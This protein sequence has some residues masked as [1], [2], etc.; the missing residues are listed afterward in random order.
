MDDLGL[1]QHQVDQNGHDI[2]TQLVKTKDFENQMKEIQSFAND[3]KDWVTNGGSGVIQAVPNWQEPTMLT[4]STG[5]GGKMAFSGN[6]L[7]FYD[8]NGNQEPRAG[9]DSEGRI[10]ADAIKAGTIEAVNIKSCL[11]ES[12]LTIGTSGGSMNVYIGTNNPR[13]ILNPW[14]GG[15]VIWAMSDNY[16]SMVSSGQFATTNGSDYTRIHPSAITVGDDDNQVLTQRNFAAHA[17]RRIKSWV[18][19]WIADWITINGTRHTIWKGIDNGA[20]MGKLRDLPGQGRNDYRYT[21]GSNDDYGYDE[22]AEGDGTDLG[23]FATP[24]DIQITDKNLWNEINNMQ[25][26]INNIQINPPTTEIDNPSSWGTSSSDKSKMLTYTEASNLGLPT[27]VAAGTV[28][29]G[30]DG[31]PYRYMEYTPTGNM[32]WFRP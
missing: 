1:I 31:R 19:L 8:A 23:Q 20:Y 3:I 2:A 22:G 21:P 27:G 29:V 9:M 28:T 26:K 6:G 14:K 15:N 10:Y 4:A 12:A 24:S 5:N 13:S 30:T 16:Q 32:H 25:S 17:Y 7:V 18:K 11:V